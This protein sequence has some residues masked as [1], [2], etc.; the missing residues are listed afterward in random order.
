MNSNANITQLFF[1]PS[2]QGAGDIKLSQP[3]TNFA[4]IVF[5]GADDNTTFVVPTIF[6][7]KILDYCLDKLNKSV[8][9]P[10]GG[11]FYIIKPYS[12][13]SSTTLFVKDRENSAVIAIYGITY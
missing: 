7:T 10:C 3:F 8:Y 4:K 5:V 11:G 6:N 1:N 2:G 12:G 13:G 9:L